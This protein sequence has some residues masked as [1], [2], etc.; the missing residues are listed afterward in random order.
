MSYASL[1]MQVIQWAQA[2][3]I[4][5]NA[6]TAAQLKKANLSGAD[7]SRADLYGADLSRAN[8]S[9]ANLSGARL[10]R[11]NLSGARL[12]RANLYG[13]NLYGADL[14][15]ADLYGADLYGADLDGADLSRADLSG[16]RLSRANLS[17]ANL[18]GAKLIGE[19]PV[20]QI[21]H[22][23]SRCDY[24]VAYLT[25][26]G[27]K[28]RTGCFFGAVDQFREKLSEEHGTNKHAME[29]TAALELIRVHAELWTPAEVTPEAE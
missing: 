19:R 12:S 24:F 21:G 20:L 2:R 10:S 6:T 27:V 11:A 23:G 13:A 9:G 4:I 5:P 18:F 8:L 3:G 26:Q 16:A 15:G 29:Y 28:L 25:D 14:S 22:I 1:E 17:G 7:L